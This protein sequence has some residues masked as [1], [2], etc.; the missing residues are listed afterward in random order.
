[1]NLFD[2]FTLCNPSQ[3]FTEEY[4]SIC[5]SNWPVTNWTEHNPLER[6]QSMKTILLNQISELSELEKILMNIPK[7]LK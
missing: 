1:M 3:K 2:F 7:E 5:N 4:H 6:A